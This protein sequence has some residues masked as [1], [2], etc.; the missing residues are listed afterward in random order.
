[1]AANCCSAASRVNTVPVW[2]MARCQI[3]D[4]V[5]AVNW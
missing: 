1:M 5:S 2:S 4:G 3:G